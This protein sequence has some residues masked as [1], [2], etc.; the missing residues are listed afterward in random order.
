MEL[1][2]LFGF[3]GAALLTLSAFDFSGGGEDDHDADPGD[4]T[5]EP[6]VDPE[7][8]LSLL[9][10]ATSTEVMGSPNDDTFLRE[11]ESAGAAGMMLD[12]G[13]GD[14]LVS[15]YDPE[16]DGNT[17]PF[18]LDFTNA[19]VDLGDGNDTLDAIMTY[20]DIDAGAGDDLVNLRVFAGGSLVDG[21][22]GDDT[23]IG[24]LSAGDAA[25]LRG[26]SGNDLID[27]SAMENV[28]AL[29]EDG[30]DTILFSG[31]DQPGA[32]YVVRADGGDGDD[33]LWYRGG[34]FVSDIFSP[35]DATGGE[36]E[37]LFRV[38]FT[39]SGEW[40]AEASDPGDGPVYDPS[41]T[42][43]IIQDFDPAEDTLLIEPL[44]E[45]DSFTPA[46]A[47][48]RP[49]EDEGTT[50]VVISYVHDTQEA[51]ELVIR[52]NSD[53][54]TW[55]DIAFLGEQVPD[56]SPEPILARPGAT[57]LGTDTADF[58]T[59]D[60]TFDYSTLP[61]YPGAFSED[62]YAGGGDDTVSFGPLDGA[63][64]LGQEDF[65]YAS[66]FG[67]TGDDLIEIVGGWGVTIDG[68]DGD[69]TLRAPNLTGGLLHGGDGN[70]S[71]SAGNAG[72]S[73]VSLYGDAGDDTLSG[74]RLFGGDG[75][76]LLWTYD[77]ADGGAGND[78]INGYGSI[79]PGSGNGSEGV[80]LRGGD[81]ADTFV[82]RVNVD[83]SDSVISR[84]YDQDGV[85]REAAVR[86]Y[87]FEPGV[88]Q[89]IIEP[90]A[91]PE[92]FT[93]TTAEMVE[94]SLGTHISLTY[95]TAENARVVDLDLYGTSG[96]DWDDIAFQGTVPQTLVPVAVAT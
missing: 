54:I 83:S 55:D 44:T 43:L 33:L 26:G 92:G 81:G 21:G 32:G 24:E 88:D 96:L 9:L 3:L 37:D 38:T 62:V 28:S 6:V 18:T 49:G 89:L 20:S 29:G 95:E 61:E 73:P 75:D 12:A 56:V 47:E 69:D 67:E 5:E 50:D 76:D 90:D 57:I 45:D 71:M 30:D 77:V 11:T 8:P 63:G 53:T 72:N 65:G 2:A 79:S 34:P 14:D 27:A 19:A 68:G 35:G 66:V 25:A 46:T 36:G 60:P 87:D 59:N 39:A 10:D 86:L 41:H 48:L 13:A 1:F 40:L 93:L 16:A 23:L 64:R 17:D 31:A 15:L 70:D 82:T 22:D 51:R 42:A 91:P 80:S 85:Y 94:D 7:A 84:Y 74:S 58:I 52:V 4:D 78:T